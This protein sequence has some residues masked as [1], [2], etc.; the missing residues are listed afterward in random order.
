MENPANQ[1]TIYTAKI[2]EG[3]WAALASVEV[4]GAETLLATRR[5][6]LAQSSK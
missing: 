3:L 5:K 1:I 4:F 6:L 2:A